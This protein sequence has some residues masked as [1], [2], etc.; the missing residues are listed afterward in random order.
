VVTSDRRQ[1][2]EWAVRGRHPI[3]ISIS[4]T[5]L[6]E[7]QQQ[8]VGQSIQPLG[9]NTPM[10]GRLSMS[11]T[12]VLMNRA[13]HPNAAKVFIN[14]VLSREGQQLFAQM[15]DE[16]SRRVDVEGDPAT[17]PDPRVEYPPSINKE[18]NV[19]YQR[20]AIQIAQEMLR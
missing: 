13:P 5:S 11:K 2:I 12:I 20:R 19:H 15:I 17:K 18:A 8:G 1:Q 9:F 14:W 4:N 7:F 10:G 3:G 6:P 16:N